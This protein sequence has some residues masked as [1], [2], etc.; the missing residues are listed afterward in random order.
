MRKLLFLLL[1]IPNILFA[2][3]ASVYATIKLTFKNGAYVEYTA[4]SFWT[5][6]D[7]MHNYYKYFFWDTETRVKDT[8]YLCWFDNS[9]MNPAARE[10]KRQDYKNLR[11]KIEATGNEANYFEE[12]G[13]LSDDW[14]VSIRYDQLETAIDNVDRIIYKDG[15]KYR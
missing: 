1:I 15:T 5:I 3:N 10:T 14:C 7:H 9:C 8:D 11:D 12:N 6:W 13:T 2:L 4:N